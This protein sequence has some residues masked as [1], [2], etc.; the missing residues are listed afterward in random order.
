MNKLY[1]KLISSNTLKIILSSSVLVYILSKYNS[2]F[3]IPYI[4]LL[5]FVPII[6]SNILLKDLKSKILISFLSII[7]CLYFSIG[8]ISL[9][10][11]FIFF[12]ILVI[13]TQYDKINKEYIKQFIIVYLLLKFIVFVSMII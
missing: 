4:T 1:K 5:L 7:D 10:Y 6:L 13:L 2:I 12:A 8:I 11:L 3:I 9:L